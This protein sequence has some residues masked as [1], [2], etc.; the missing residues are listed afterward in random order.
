MTHQDLLLALGVELPARL[1]DVSAVYE[2]TPFLLESFNGVPLALCWNQTIAETLREI[3]GA[4]EE[5]RWRDKQVAAGNCECNRCRREQAASPEIAQRY[6]EDA[7]VFEAAV[8]RLRV[9]QSSVGWFGR[10]VFAFVI[11]FLNGRA[12]ICHAFARLYEREGTAR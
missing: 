3:L 2:K 8:A 6:R 4:P 5:A 7:A 12:G 9:Y 1:V 10:K 11:G